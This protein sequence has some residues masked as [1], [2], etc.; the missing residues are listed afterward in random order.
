MA[1]VE[2]LVHELRFAEG[3]PAGAIVLLHG[4]GTSERDLIPLLDVLDPVQRLVAAFP[5]GPHELAPLGHHWYV[6]A[7]AGRPDPASFGDSLARLGTWLEGIAAETGVP[8][9]R[10]VIGGFS[11][12]A[13]M[14]WVLSLGPGRPRPAGLLAMSGFIPAVPGLGLDLRSLNGFPIA[15]SHGVLDPIVPVEFARDARRRTRAR[16]ADVF[17]RETE[18]PH[19]VDPRIVPGLVDWVGRRFA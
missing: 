1:A 16:G 3:D 4:R 10:T 11:Q 8:I 9:E 13:A 5:R 17:Y 18:V 14:A 6:A 19:I 2:D 15:I 12:G 7:E